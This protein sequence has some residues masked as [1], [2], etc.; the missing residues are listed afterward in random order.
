MNRPKLLG[1]IAVVG[2][3]GLL[4]S[5]GPV[6]AGSGATATIGEANQKY[7]FA[8]K[9]VYVNVG[10]TVTWTNGTDAAHTVTSDSGTELDSPTIAAAKAFA[11]TF[12]ATGTF[13]YHCTIHPYAV[14][15]VVV[16]AAGVAPP[17][18][19]TSPVVGKGTSDR[20]IGLAIL[21][22]AGLAGAALALRRF[23]TTV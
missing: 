10:G 14:G 12:A 8:P 22:L 15:K 9:T 2:V 6:V 23:R 21:V 3:L 11:H 17:A 18:T 7:Y 19:D 4:V 5:A 13:T 1:V 20:P 16:L